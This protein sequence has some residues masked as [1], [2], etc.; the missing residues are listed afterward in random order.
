MAGRSGKARGRN[1]GMYATEKSDTGIVSKKVPNKIGRPMAEALEKRPVTKGNFC[2]DDCEL[3]AGTG[4]S[5]ER[6]RQNT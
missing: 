3:Y 5:I 2:R 1:P 4:G 6:T